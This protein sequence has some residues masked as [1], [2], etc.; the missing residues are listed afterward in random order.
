MTTEILPNAFVFQ[1]ARNSV[2]S[3]INQ[4]LQCLE[5]KKTEMFAVIKEL[6]DQYI[7]KQKQKQ[8]KIN[9][10]NKLITQTKELADNSLT[11]VQNRIIEDLQNELNKASIQESDCSVEFEWGFFRDVISMIHSIKLKRVD[12]RKDKGGTLRKGP[13]PPPK[14]EFLLNFKSTFQT[15]TKMPPE[16]LINISKES[17]FKLYT[18]V[19]LLYTRFIQFIL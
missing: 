4:I 12:T 13:P 15:E 8:K 5:S 6:E 17:P 9:E 2:Q 16:S 11:K 14:P 19:R 7:S 10:I 3:E 1:E 18:T